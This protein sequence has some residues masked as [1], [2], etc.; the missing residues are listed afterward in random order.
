MHATLRGT[1]SL[2]V[3]VDGVGPELPEPNKVAIRV[4][5]HDPQVGHRQQLLEDHAERVRFAGPAL[6]T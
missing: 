3:A 1:D 2:D 4:K 5:Y 6:S